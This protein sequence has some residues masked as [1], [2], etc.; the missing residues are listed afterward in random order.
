MAVKG[1]LQAEP[2]T[3]TLSGR[4]LLVSN[5]GPF[6]HHVGED[7]RLVRRPTGGGVATALSSL[8]GSHD[9][10]WIAGPVSEGDQE[11]VA[12]G[13][14]YASLGDGYRLRFADVSPD[15]YRLFYGTF[16]NPILWFLQH[17]LWDR[18][19]RPNLSEA[20]L[21]AWEKGYLPANQEFAEAVVDE[22]GRRD[23][24]T[25]VMSHDYHLYLTP[26]FIRDHCPGVRLQHFIHIPWPGPEAWQ[27]L[28]AS[29]TRSLCEG[30]IAND[31]VVFQT[32]ASVQNF[33]LTCRAFLPGA[34][35]NFE[36]S[37]V[38]CRGRH[39][40]VSVNPISVDV[41]GLRRQL[42]SPE[43]QSYRTRFA[44]ETAERTI[45]RVDRL[46][47]SKNVLGGFQAFDSLLRR[48]PEWS[49][50]VRFLAFLVPSRE[51]VPEYCRYREEVFAL[52]ENI[53]RRY[54]SR[55]WQPISIFYEQNRPQAFAA[56]S[57]YDVLLVNSLSD[58]MN[59]VAK[60]GP[61]LNERD[62]V[63]V[64]S[65]TAGAYQELW[66]GA[67]PVWPEDIE[68]TADDLHLALMMTSSERTE[69]A[70]SLRRAIAAH[71]IDRWLQVQLD[72][73]AAIEAVSDNPASRL[74]RR[75]EEG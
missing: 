13:T 5:R 23:D 14:T 57:Q 56:L 34:V 61:V 9:I 12:R 7:G 11:L 52:V 25:S 69:R 33:L 26:L 16:S 1:T 8:N 63:L 24:S 59:L 31:S 53:N 27:V 45:V 3:R 17:S 35:V 10:T 37:T 15:S 67:L 49:E 39:V 20:I 75:D 42:A 66:E 51:S 60:E 46:D 6:E 43:V 62:G 36:D 48:Y 72:E 40:R 4:L 65:V 30:L 19:E 47:P 18:L 50:R 21:H 73:L 41:A 71:D 29:I 54:G 22:I 64:L 44:A 38:S 70:R 74:P 58:G 55:A 2:R 68:G 32:W 28:P